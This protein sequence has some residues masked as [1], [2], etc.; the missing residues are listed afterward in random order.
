MTLTGGLISSQPPL[1]PTHTHV[2]WG[3]KWME[4][5]VHLGPDREQPQLPHC[6]VRAGLS[7]SRPTAW[8][9]PWGGRVLV[10]W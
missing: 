5:S 2:L 6:T 1:P 4:K 7:N 8:L 3:P 9:P 10:N